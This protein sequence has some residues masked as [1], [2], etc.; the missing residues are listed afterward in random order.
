MYFSLY[1]VRPLNPWVSSDRQ[2]D[3]GIVPTIYGWRPLLDPAAQVYL[4]QTARTI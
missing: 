2:C 3:V 1:L 4:R